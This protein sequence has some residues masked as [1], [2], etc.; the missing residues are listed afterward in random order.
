[1]D[2][3]KKPP[4]SIFSV[5]SV[6]LCVLCVP[7]LELP[8]PTAPLIIVSVIARSADLTG[9]EDLS[10]LWLERGLDHRFS[11]LGGWSAKVKREV[12]NFCSHGKSFASLRFC[13]PGQPGRN[14][15]QGL[16]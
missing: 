5:S 2:S 10:G 8:A 15:D 13:T 16:E 3:K 7:N 9:L 6:L 14:Y 11:H 1:M 4:P 12:R